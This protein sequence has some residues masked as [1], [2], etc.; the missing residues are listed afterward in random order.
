MSAA[1]PPPPRAEPPID[2]SP[3]EV[4]GID[5]G[6]HRVF[7]SHRLDEARFVQPG[8]RH[9]GLLL[10]WFDDDGSGHRITDRLRELVAVDSAE[11]MML[12]DA[13]AGVIVDSVADALDLDAEDLFELRVLL[14]VPSSLGPRG[15]RL[16]RDAFSR[17]GLEIAACDVVDRSIAAMAG[18]LAHRVELSGRLPAGPV[19]VVDN[20]GGDVSLTIADP[21][22]E[23]LLLVHPLSAG[24]DDD[25]AAVTERLRRCLTVGASLSHRDGIVRP[26]DW[27]AVSSRFGQVIVTGSGHDQPL[28]LELLRS[29]L[30]AADIMP[31]PVRAA[32]RCVVAGLT[33]LDQYL[34]WT[35]CWPTLDLTHGDR[36]LRP[37]GPLREHDGESV[38]VDGGRILQLRRDG[39]ILPLEAGDHLGAGIGVPKGLGPLPVARFLPDGRLLLLGPQGTRPLGLQVDW[40]PPGDDDDVVTL[41]SIGRR[42]LTMVSQ[43][44]AL[45]R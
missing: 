28:L 24:P 6:R 20:D 17:Q 21:D 34:G 19:A 42:G 11:A 8:D 1:Q 38:V 23:R 22:T 12:A 18:W 2:D 37:A 39:R 35:A 27:S 14:G 30:P 25:P 31:D 7:A 40:P 26:D 41:S 10:R 33:R 32:E 16:L 5:L 15:R 36:L 9:D 13:V 43:D 44:V 29:V 4:V 3:R 45:G